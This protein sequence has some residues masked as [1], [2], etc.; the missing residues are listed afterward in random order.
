MVALDPDLPARRLREPSGNR[1]SQSISFGADT[2]RGEAE[3]LFK[4]FLLDTPARC[5]DQCLTLKY[6]SS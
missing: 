3:V 6:G 4:N 1:Q 2:L 5:R